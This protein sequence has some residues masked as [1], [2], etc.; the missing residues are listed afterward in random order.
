MKTDNLVVVSEYNSEVEAEMAKSLLASGGIESEIE[1]GI[2]S[3][4]YPTGISPSRL[5]V[6]E[7][8]ALQAEKVLNGRY[9]RRKH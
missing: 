9:Q 5:L 2:M 6:R 8:D 7:E 1:D 4:M 3:S